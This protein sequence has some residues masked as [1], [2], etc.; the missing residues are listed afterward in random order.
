[1]LILIRDSNTNS[2][3]PADLMLPWYT[4]VIS[5]TAAFLAMLLVW[6]LL[7]RRLVRLFGLFVAMLIPIRLQPLDTQVKWPI[8]A[9]LTKALVGPTERL[10][11]L[12]FRSALSVA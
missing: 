7:F 12:K 8:V 3:G 1:M 9:Q 4:V 5:G 2:A 10:I 11:C 6:N